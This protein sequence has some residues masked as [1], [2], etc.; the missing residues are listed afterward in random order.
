MD[1]HILYSLIISSNTTIKQA[2]QKLNETGRK[3]L[4]VT[5]EYSRILGVIT[6][7]DIRDALL[8][9]MEFTVKVDKVMNTNYIYVESYRHDKLEKVKQLMLDMNVSQIPSID[10]SGIIVDLFVWTDVF[11]THP[12]RKDKEYSN[13][14]IVMAG[15]KGTRLDP[16]TKIFP[17]PLIPI[18]DKPVIEHIME[19]FHKFGFNRF[20]YTLNYK[21][22]Y[23]KLFLKE[24]NF[25]YAIDFIEE[26]TFLGTAGSLSLLR[27][28]IEE[29]FFVINCDSLLDLDFEEL[30]K[31]HKE[32]AVAIT[33][34]GCHNEVNIP[35]GVLDIA[36]GKL[37]RI[38]EKPSN[39]VIINTGAY[40][41]E[42]HVISYLTEG[43]FIDM[44]TLID[45]VGA[46][47]KIAVFPICGGWYDLGQWEE[48]HNALMK[49]G[50]E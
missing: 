40:V 4:F 35:F 10:S 49:I 31:W 42:P 47:D 19:R 34:V 48:Y 43:R 29:T 46:K 21:K 2:M 3:I 30:L 39:D 16:F 9:G 17:K 50:G 5:D 36:D 41:M 15:G 6:D 18:N 7:G 26:E 24:R 33:I 38:R 14:V 13:Q 8:C 45:T 37:L 11:N 20:T 22:E 12:H 27:N 32:Q 44:N 25:P 28:K 23:I 1:K